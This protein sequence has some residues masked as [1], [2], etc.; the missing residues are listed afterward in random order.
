[1]ATGRR[2]QTLVAAAQAF[3]DPA[4]CAQLVA[5]ARWP[6]GPSCPSCSST[7]L[8]YLHSRHLWKCRRCARQFSV[9]VGTLFES[10]PLPLGTWLTAIWVIA[11][12]PDGEVSAAELARAV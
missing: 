9:K 4:C 3:A 8:S 1:M 7:T 2:P 10:S 11:N 5:S 6:R 12:A